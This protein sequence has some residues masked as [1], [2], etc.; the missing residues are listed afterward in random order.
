MFKRFLIFVL[1]NIFSANLS[2]SAFA[3]QESQQLRIITTVPPIASIFASIGKDKVKISSIASANECAHN[4]SIKPSQAAGLRYADLFVY[5]DDNFELY[6]PKIIKSASA[7]ILKLS[8]LGGI[9]LIKNGDDINWHFWLNLNNVEEVATAAFHTLAELRPNDKE[10]FS[11]NYGAFIKKV[12]DMQGILDKIIV[13]NPIYISPELDYLFTNNKSIITHFVNMNNLSPTNVESLRQLTNQYSA[14]CIFASDHLNS[15]KIQEIVGKIK[16]V[17]LEA[18]TWSYV[19]GY[20]QLFTE[21][22]NKIV[23]S[24][25]HCKN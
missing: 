16:V 12:H 17:T 7:K 21:Y 3:A 4:Y 9:K 25:E 22:F 1:F 2:I 15:A 6:V 14:K 19:S 20:E 24:L 11:A 18:E 10:Y 8:D 23:Y 5:V 13:L